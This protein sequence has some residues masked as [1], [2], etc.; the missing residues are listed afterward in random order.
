M[1]FRFC[2]KLR[3]SLLSTLADFHQ[4]YALCCKQTSPLDVP[5][6]AFGFS[7]FT[8]YAFSDAPRLCE[9]RTNLPPAVLCLREIRAFL[10]FIIIYFL[11]TFF[12]YSA[13]VTL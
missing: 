5:M 4:A 7:L 12:L 9:K 3:I 8:L 13:G 10:Q 6:Y 11:F 2:I 1:I